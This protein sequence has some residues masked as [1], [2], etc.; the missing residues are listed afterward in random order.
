MAARASYSEGLA[1]GVLSFGSLA[2]LSTAS[3][4]ATARI[5][6][7][8][9]LGR[10]A[11]I[12]AAVNATLFLST[13]QERPGF[14]RAITVLTPRAPRVTGLF[15][16]VFAFSATLTIVVGLIT[17]I[18]V[19]FLFTGPIHQPELFVP[20]VVNIASYVILENSSGNIDGLL[21]AFR[22]GRLLFVIRLVQAASLF[23]IAVALGLTLD[24]VWG[25]VLAS[26][27]SSAIALV[28]R[29]CFV[30]RY[31]RWSVEPAAMAYGRGHL[32][33][34][35]RF[36]MKIVPGSLCDG[37]SSESGTW[38]LGLTS[39]LAV[40]GAYNRAWTIVR[41]FLAFNFR[42]TEMLF[43]TLVE[44]SARHDPVG[45]DRALVDTLRYSLIGT[46]LLAAVGGAAAPGIMAL[47]GP[48][49]GLASNALAILLWAPGLMILASCQ[50]NALY[51][52]GRPLL[53]TASASLRMLVTLASGV[54]LALW[55][56][57]T[58][59]ATALCLGLVT[60]LAFC[61]AIVVRVLVTPLRQLWPVR[62]AVGAFVAYVI[63]FAVGRW[64]YDSIQNLSGLAI[65]LAVA[66]A[67][68]PLV[69]LLVGGLTK[70]DRG[71]LRAVERRIRQ[72]SAPVVAFDDSGA[73]EPVS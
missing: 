53:G 29:I 22:A 69:F 6:G 43:P 36:G 54:A 16:A 33:D 46:L 57:P 30:R 31:M 42:I 65:S 56:G 27:G 14:V 32:G 60:D 17:T 72:H 73:Q 8:D 63:V 59:V 28:L 47:F 13:A 34:I 50:R 58:G 62:Q 64:L 41:Q 38:I 15:L 21:S 1:Y 44:R 25:L 61:S 9:T 48:G 40:V 49:F 3:S 71:R 52:L 68:Y 39:T 2:V 23:A 35:I 70:G 11:L 66:S 67:L 19:Y 26:V 55:L 20:A 4:I 18:I 12:A 5:Y 37:V 24:T 7:I 45:F 51:A 10:Y